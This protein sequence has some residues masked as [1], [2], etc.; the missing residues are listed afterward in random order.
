MVEKKKKREAVDVTK[1]LP[2]AVWKF[3]ALQLF[4]GQWHRKQPM[5]IRKSRVLLKSGNSDDKCHESESEKVGSTRKCCIC[6]SVENLLKLK[7]SGGWMKEMGT[8]CRV[9]I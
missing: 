6:K 9:F 2:T 3:Y 8:H 1:S 5:L 7:Y 4:D